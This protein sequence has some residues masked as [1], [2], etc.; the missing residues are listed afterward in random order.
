[1]KKGGYPQGLAWALRDF[2]PCLL[3]NHW[4]VWWNAGP[5]ISWAVSPFH[6]AARKLS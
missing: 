6:V 2:L 4:L 5:W 3:K 1:M